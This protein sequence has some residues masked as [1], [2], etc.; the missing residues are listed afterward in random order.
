MELEKLIEEVR[1]YYQ[2]PPFSEDEGLVAYAEGGMSLLGGLNP[3]ANIKEDKTYQSLLKDY[4]NYAYHYKGDDF[5]R[6]YEDAIL[7]WQAR[8]EVPE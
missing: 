2:I 5:I 6:N 1:R 8:T 7:S 3:F 4:I